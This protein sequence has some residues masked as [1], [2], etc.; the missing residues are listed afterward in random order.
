[1]PYL[2]E[3]V[4]HLGT[5]LK[6][7]SPWNDQKVLVTGVHISELAEPTRFLEGG[8]LLLST[9][10]QLTNSDFDVDE[11]IRNLHAFGIAGFGFGLG[12]YFEEVPEH[13]ARACS[14][15]GLP[16]F[17]VPTP[18]PFQT[19]NEVFWKLQMQ[20]Q[21]AEL[22]STLDRQ[23]ALIQSSASDQPI[24]AVLSELATMGN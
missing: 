5:D 14:A 11:Y 1:M 12:P 8:E 2:H 23:S 22:L 6:P 13:L 20:A 19:I 4:E 10:L 17:V 18:T 24:T 21:N 3:I 15:V 7:W 16:L 9:G